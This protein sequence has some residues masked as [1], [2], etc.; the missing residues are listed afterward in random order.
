MQALQAGAAVVPRMKSASLDS[1]DIGATVFIWLGDNHNERGA[2][3]GLATLTAFEAITIAQVRDPTKQKDAFRLTLALVSAQISAPLT[4][5][6]L[7]PYR[8]VEGADG[9]ESLGRIHRDRN[10][11]IIRL[12]IGESA[13]LQARFRN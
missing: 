10:D 7:S 3:H 8:Y 1:G 2:L 13:V 9:I 5:D 6:D 4:T 11:K 12:T